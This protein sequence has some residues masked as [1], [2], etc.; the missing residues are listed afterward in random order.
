VDA[1]N[2]G[3]WPGSEELCRWVHS[4]NAMTNRLAVVAVTVFVAVGLVGGGMA[5]TSLGSLVDGDGPSVESGE[6]VATGATVH[7]DRIGRPTAVG[8]VL[9][10]KETALTGVTV[11][12]TFYQ[13]GE[14]VQT[15]TGTIIGGP[16]GPNERA[17]FAIRG[18]E[19]ATTPDD[20]EVEVTDHEATDE[21]TLAGLTVVD[22]EF[23]NQSA[24]QVFVNGEVRNGADR[25]VAPLVVATFY[26]ENGSV[27]GVR[28]S[29]TSTSSL[30][31]GDETTFQIRFRTFGD[32]PSRA[33][34]L[35]TVRFRVVE[36][37]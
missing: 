29:R 20:V 33:R 22:Y 34:E 10:G 19:I 28:Q 9:N 4:L 24:D 17:P 27:I 6:V 7:R 35:A 31:P 5:L 1:G 12:V 25:S 2:T 11:E 21:D 36:A 26:D 23:D 13:D 32:V 15:A 37:G 14:A 3:V 16:V 18:T 30:A 8:E